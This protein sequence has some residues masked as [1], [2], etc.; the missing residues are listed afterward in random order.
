MSESGNQKPATGSIEEKLYP[1]R[2]SESNAILP[3]FDDTPELLAKKAIMAQFAFKVEL[4]NPEF[5]TNPK[6]AKTKEYYIHPDSDNKGEL[7]RAKLNAIINHPALQ[8]VLPESKIAELKAM[9]D[10]ANDAEIVSNN[11]DVP[12]LTTL[13]NGVVFVKPLF[14]VIPGEPT[15]VAAVRSAM[16]KNWY[17]EAEKDINPEI[18][19]RT[20]KLDF[21]NDYNVTIR[22]IQALRQSPEVQKHLGEKGM[23]ELINWEVRGTGAYTIN[24][25]DAWRKA[26]D[27]KKDWPSDI[28]ELVDPLLINGSGK[29]ELA[30]QQKAIGEIDKKVADFIAGIPDEKARKQLQELYNKSSDRYAANAAEVIDIAKDPKFANFDKKLA[31]L[32]GI[33][34][35]GPDKKIGSSGL[36]EVEYLGYSAHVI[37]KGMGDFVYQLGQLK[38]QKVIGK[39]Q[40][41]QIEKYITSCEQA[42]TVIMFEGNMKDRMD[43]VLPEAVLNEVYVSKA[44]QEKGVYAKVDKYPPN[45]P[46]LVSRFEGK[47]GQPTSF[48]PKT[49][50]ITAKE[51]AGEQQ[52]SAAQ[53]FDKIATVFVKTPDGKGVSK[54]DLDANKDRVLTIDEINRVLNSPRVKDALPGQ[55]ILS[56]DQV[57]R[58]VAIRKSGKD[59]SEAEMGSAKKDLSVEQNLA[60]ESF[61]HLTRIAIGSHE[62]DLDTNGDGVLTS[63]EASRNL[64]D[65]KV[66][67]ALAQMP[68]QKAVLRDMVNGSEVVESVDHLESIF[69]TTIVS[70]GTDESTKQ[71][72]KLH[73]VNGDHKVSLGEALQHSEQKKGLA[74]TAQVNK[75]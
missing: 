1:L 50:I 28:R 35:Y 30:T 47:D 56:A 36:R 51:A 21:N 8:G 12:A 55:S 62:L 17:I 20:L 2:V 74:T 57:N 11:P 40:K 19:K 10:S 39:D 60:L 63:L 72:I 73:D 5:A 13:A 59:I 38:N 75:P 4:P 23:Q 65:P 24:I 29:I 41:E 61:K 54:Y 44:A 3:S 71:F 52:I 45:S 64:N 26:K 27:A 68:E 32:L 46:E 37:E 66:H 43:R 42:K 14:E 48:I 16:Y 31:P 34:G 25:L 58:L 70:G 18:G 49:R 15:N 33:I 69:K 53:A 9:A 7:S 22:E 67:Q 6:A